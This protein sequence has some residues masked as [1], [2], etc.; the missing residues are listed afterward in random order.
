[1]HKNRVTTKK[2][3][4][5]WGY[6]WKKW[7][8]VRSVKLSE[9]GQTWKS[10]VIS[11]HNFIIRLGYVTQLPSIILTHFGLRI[12]HTHIKLTEWKHTYQATYPFV[13]HCIFVCLRLASVDTVKDEAPLHLGEWNI[14]SYWPWLDI[15]PKHSI[16]C[17]LSSPPLLKRAQPGLKSFGLAFRQKAQHVGALLWFEM[18]VLL[19]P[20]VD[21]T[22]V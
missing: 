7:L 11:L 16:Q 5:R 19:D 8:F 1:M 20:S 2:N 13:S 10:S 12:T 18:W 17:A 6:F 3:I 14:A 22:E 9:T 21:N 4:K 15:L